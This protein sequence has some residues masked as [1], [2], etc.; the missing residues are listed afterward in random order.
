MDLLRHKIDKGLRG[1]SHKLNVIIW[2][3]LGPS[4]KLADPE[5]LCENHL[6]E[7]GKYEG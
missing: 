7:M 2:L 5:M 3:I 6:D 4:H 1:N